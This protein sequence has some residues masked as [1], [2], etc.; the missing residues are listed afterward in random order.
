MGKH[1]PIKN[2]RMMKWSVDGQAWHSMPHS[3]YVHFGLGTTY[4]KMSGL[5]KADVIDLVKQGSYEPLG[6]ELLQEAW[7]LQQANPRSALVMGVAAVETRLKEFVG[8]VV[9]DARWL[10]T[11]VQ[12][13]PLVQMLTEYLP[14]LPAKNSIRGKVL[15]PPPAILDI[16]KKG[17][18]LRNQI[19]HGKQSQVN[20]DELD[21]LL[22]AARDT[23]FLLDFY[24]GTGWAWENIR[25]ET[26]RAMIAAHEKKG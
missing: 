10:A 3:F 8:D 7:A 9:P 21:A 20:R 6:Q 11:N 26:Q 19:V 13:P 25:I 5:I 22:S 23:I 24:G 12:S 17:V 2:F 1:N 16:L 18:L 14:T 15:A 4:K